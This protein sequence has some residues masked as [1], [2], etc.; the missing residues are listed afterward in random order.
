LADGLGFFVTVIV[1]Q[2]IVA[3]T[4][5]AFAGVAPPI[6]AFLGA[7]GML[8]LNLL[9][10]VALTL[11]LGTFF[12]SRPAVIGIT[13]FVLFLQVRLAQVAAFGQFLPGALLFGAAE[14]FAGD[15]LQML[16]GDPLPYT[17]PLVSAAVLTVLFTVAAFRRF[18]REEF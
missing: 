10:Y 2:G 7:M 8:F 1:V 3:Y 11:M 16:A 9:F 17:I 4:Q 18:G 15:P 14:T 6:P 5:L 12:D 13:V